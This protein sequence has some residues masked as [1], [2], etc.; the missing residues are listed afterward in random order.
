MLQ[1]KLQAKEKLQLKKRKKK[2]MKSALFVNNLDMI[3]MFGGGAV[4][5]ELGLMLTV[6]AL[7]KRH[8][9]FVTY[10]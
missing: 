7:K 10:A 9:I 6:L 3:M 4:L 2:V 5:V 8:C 1:E